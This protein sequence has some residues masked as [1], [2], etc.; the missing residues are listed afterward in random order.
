MT[1]TVDGTLLMRFPPTITSYQWACGLP[2]DIEDEEDINYDVS[3]Y[4]KGNNNK[5]NY[6]LLFV[7]YNS[8]LELDNDE[9]GS[10]YIYTK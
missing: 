1:H 9:T 6:S 7:K 5:K 3:F 8:L 2:I 4:S 10:K